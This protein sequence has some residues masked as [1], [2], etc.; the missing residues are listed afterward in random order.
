M[1]ERRADRLWRWYGPRH[2]SATS[3]ESESHRWCAGE[4]GEGVEGFRQEWELPNSLRMYSLQRICMV[5]N[6]ISNRSIVPHEIVGGADCCISSMGHSVASLEVSVCQ[7]HYDLGAGQQ[8]ITFT[9][10]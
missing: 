6:S 7:L 3:G 10:I 2:T 5:C 4:A 8:F 9:V 1:Q